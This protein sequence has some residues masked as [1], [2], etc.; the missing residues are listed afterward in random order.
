M[1]I[2]GYTS[3]KLKNLAQEQDFPLDLP[4]NKQKILDVDTLLLF[5]EIGLKPTFQDKEKLQNF[6]GA[7]LLDMGI[8]IPVHIEEGNHTDQINEESYWI[9]NLLYVALT[10]NSSTPQKITIADGFNDAENV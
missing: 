6:I 8:T 2:E 5:I 7:A 4:E 3:E 9:G 10:Y 1:G